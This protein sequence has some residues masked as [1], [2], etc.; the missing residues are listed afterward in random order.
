MP[1][2][3]VSKDLYGRRILLVWISRVFARHVLVGICMSFLPGTVAEFFTRGGIKSGNSP[4]LL[5][6]VDYLTLP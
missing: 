5:S 3:V 6:R 2:L 4:L 1:N